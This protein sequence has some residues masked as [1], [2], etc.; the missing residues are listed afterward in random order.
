[1]SNLTLTMKNIRK[2]LAKS[3]IVLPMHVQEEIS[4]R[5][6]FKRT[7]FNVCGLAK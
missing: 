6:Y 7:S 1:M 4:K 5:G 3:N 2:E